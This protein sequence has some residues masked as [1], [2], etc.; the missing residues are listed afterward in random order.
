MPALVCAFEIVSPFLYP[1]LAV[2]LPTSFQKENVS[3]GLIIIS[4][5][6]GAAIERLTALLCRHYC[7]A[8]EEYR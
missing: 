5:I 3:P 8:K 4:F 6:L 2:V 7:E 1:F